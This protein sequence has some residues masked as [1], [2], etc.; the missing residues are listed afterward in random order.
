V[1]CSFMDCAEFVPGNAVLTVG[2]Q[3]RRLGPT[4]NG[5]YERQ[6]HGEWTR[7]RRCLSALHAKWAVARVLGRVVKEIYSADRGI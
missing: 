2:R 4:I 6:T 1:W 7:Q 5:G 3:I